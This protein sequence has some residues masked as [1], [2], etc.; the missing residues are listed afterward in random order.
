MKAG[1]DPAR[2]NRNIGTSKSGHGQNNRLVISICDPEAVYSYESLASYGAISRKV[3]RRQ[4]T[5]LVEKT[6][7]DSYH[8]CTVDDIA[9]L[10]QYVAPADLEGIELIVLRQP[11]RNEEI[12][13][14]LW[15][16]IGYYVEI[17]R[18]RGRAIFIEA[19]SLS[20]PMRWS[21]SLIPEIERELERLRNDG[22]EITATKRHHIVS[23]SLE[24]VR[25]TQLYRTLLH[26]LG[27]HI[28]YSQN[29]SSFGSKLPSEKESFAHRYADRVRDEL[30]RK[31]VIPFKRIVD[32]KGIERDGL[33]M[34]DFTAIQQIVGPDVGRVMVQN[35]KR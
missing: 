13:N 16:R 20:K 7:A 14:P 8:A 25:A 26:E 15:G 23:S 11:K 28:D 33:R 6:R 4:I 31:K 34:S 30:Q 3:N 29:P 17:G 10:L 22:H 24:S 2:R 18:H 12:L 21:K 19:V 27:H 9:H 35:R 32:P 5:F 1:H